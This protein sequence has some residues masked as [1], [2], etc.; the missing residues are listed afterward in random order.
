MGAFECQA[1]LERLA[2]F[3]NMFLDTA[4]IN[5]STDLFDTTW[6]GEREL[7]MRHADRVCF[8]SDW[9]NV[10]YAYQQALDSVERFGFPAGALPGIMRHNALRFVH[11]TA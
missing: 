9:P 6:T 3:P 1:Y 8:G 4:M 7:L 5:V 10:P 11:G 2:R